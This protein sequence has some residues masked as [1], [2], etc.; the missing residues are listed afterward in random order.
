[1]DGFSVF[2]LPLLP[3]C[4]QIFDSARVNNAAL[5]ARGAVMKD[6]AARDVQP[7]TTAAAVLARCF[8][9]DGRYPLVIVPV[10]R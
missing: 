4:R 8:S 1:V 7:A 3:I 10:S 6:C 2:S 9:K 5:S